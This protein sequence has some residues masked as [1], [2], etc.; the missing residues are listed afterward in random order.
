MKSIWTLALVMLAIAGFAAEDTRELVLFP[1]GQGAAVQPAEDFNVDAE[2]LNALYAQLKQIPNLYVLRFRETS[3]SVRRAIEE[4]RVRRDRLTPPF[5]ER[6]ADGSW[7]AARVG[8]LLGVNLAFAG[9]IEEFS[10]NPTTREAVVTIS[11]DLI[12]VQ[13]GEVLISVAETGRGRLGSDQTDPNIARIA[14]VSQAAE[15]IGAAVRTRLAPPTEQ[16][17]KIEEK[18]QPDRKRERAA[19]SLFILVL[20]A[21]LGGAQF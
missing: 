10:Y 11:G 16:P 19:V 18:K 1:F 17:T 13:S 20:G 8:A 4:N 15:K 12:D 21:V 7:R 9:R 5:N 3:P 14:A 6:E 2:T